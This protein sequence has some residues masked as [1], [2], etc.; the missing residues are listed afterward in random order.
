MRRRRAIA[1]A[2]LFAAVAFAAPAHAAF[3]NVKVNVNN[4]APEETAIAIN[5]L[6]PLNIV[7][8][9][10]TPCRYYY[11]TNGGTTW[12]EGTL[13]DP[14]DLGDS[15]MAFDAAGNVF[16]CY[17]GQFF[18]SG[19]FINKSSNGGVSWFPAGAAVIQHSGQVPFEDKATHV[20]DWTGGANNG[21]IYVGWTQFDHYG[22]STVT[23]SSRILFSRS[24]NGGASY[25]A[26]VKVSDHGGN[27]V[28]S[29]DTVEG[30]VPAVGPDGTVYMAWAG[31]RGLEFDKSS[32]A[33]VTWGA[34]KTISDIVGGWDFAIPGLQRC[35]GLPVTKA[36][37]TNGPY[38]GRVYV[39]WSD[40]RLG[41]TDV[42]L[43]HSDDGGMSWSPRIRINDDAPGNGRHQFMPV[44]DIDPL[45]GTLY[46][47][48]YDRRLH[49][50][51]ATDMYL[52]Y[53]TDGGD[54]WTNTLISASSFTPAATVFFGDYIG[55]S[56][57]GGTVRPLW[58]RQ[59]GTTLSVWTALV[60]QITAVAA[61]RHASHPAAGALRA[62]PNPARDAVHL[63][64]LDGGAL[65][66]PVTIVNAA[67]RVVRRVE[68]GSGAARSEA[69][70]DGRDARGSMAPGGVY[71]AR[72][73]HG[74]AARIIWLP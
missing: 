38:R 67:G 24:T 70:W 47:V 30:A 9:A 16:Y 33:G 1:A 26:A 64:A 14:Y 40:Q 60:D 52:A 58:M 17:I 39:M 34:D 61:G 68:P 27:C 45:S 65:G 2:S 42:W 13:P 69:V 54:T 50:D 73:A 22:T 6:N 46:C 18:H 49:T 7:G 29:D 8:A 36:D 25:S 66:G 44:I 5:P 53:S 43:L 3:P 32:D 12:T 20:V 48:F 59:D 62:F 4:N 21:Y 10:Q 41:D 37:F 57:Y 55:L 63:A 71:F 31:P 28:D 72:T 11:T 56:A 23:D 51:N 19:I 74:P 15:Q 35:N